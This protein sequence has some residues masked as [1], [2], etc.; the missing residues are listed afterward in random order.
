MHPV[1]TDLMSQPEAQVAEPVSARPAG[2]PRIAVIAS[3]PAF[4][5]VLLNRVDRLGWHAMAHQAPPTPHELLD[6]RLS[7]VVVDPEVLN[8][9]VF[10]FV[11]NV[12]KQA[13]EL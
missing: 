2:R 12:A 5:Q 4:V 8:E 10:G 1:E 13:P 6:D 11:E 7:A 3:D 9:D